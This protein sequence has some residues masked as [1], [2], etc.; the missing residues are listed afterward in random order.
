[1]SATVAQCDSDSPLTSHEYGVGERLAARLI[2]SICSCSTETARLGGKMRIYCRTE[3]GKINGFEM[4]PSAT[5]RF[6]VLEL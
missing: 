5:D 2:K 4:I 6:L 3:E 1:M